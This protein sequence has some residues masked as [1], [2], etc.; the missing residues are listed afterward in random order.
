MKLVLKTLKRE[1]FDIE[2]NGDESVL[3]LKEKIEAKY[4]FPVAHQ[5]LI[6][7]GAILEDAKLLSSYGLKEGSFLVLMVRAVST[8]LCKFTHGQII[9]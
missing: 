5:K 1:Q 4:T 2:G 7:A 8:L 3:K 9:D 6:F